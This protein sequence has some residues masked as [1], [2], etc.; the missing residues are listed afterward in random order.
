M[1]TN[2][3]ID[4]KSSGIASYD[5][6][7]TFTVLANP[8]TVANGGL[9][10]SS[11]TTYAVLCGGTT[12]TN[13]VQSIAS[14]GTANDVLTSNGASALPTFKTP[15]GGLIYEISSNANSPI[16]GATYFISQSITFIG[17]TTSGSAGTRY[18]IVQTGTIKTCY[19]AITVQGTLGS[20]ENCTI[21]LRLNNTTDTNVTTTLQLTA[22]SNAFNNSGLSIAV[23]AG[24]YFEVKF[25]GPTWATNPTTVAISLSVYIQ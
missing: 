11:L 17:T 21:A 13:P 6:A 25:I 19:G 10:V 12:T 24:D 14:V 3:A 20:N 18:Y 9:G 7:G 8:L 2:N 22:A 15:N 16:D 4:L 23:A 1:A 5:A